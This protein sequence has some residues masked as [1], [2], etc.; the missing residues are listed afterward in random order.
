MKI[1]FT[2]TENNGNNFPQGEVSISYP[3][4]N[5]DLNS[6]LENLI[7]PAL[8]GLTYK[9]VDEFFHPEE[10]N[11]KEELYKED[12][13]EK[14][15]KEFFDDIEKN[16]DKIKEFTEDKK[17]GEKIDITTEKYKKVIDD[18]INS[19]NFKKLFIPEQLIMLLEEANKYNITNK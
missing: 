1:T 4:D 12:Y 7:I 11:E 18:L 14:V 16:T 9:G 17:S 2:P 3:S 10:N 13:E 5:M 8:Y 19:K 15:E 6:M